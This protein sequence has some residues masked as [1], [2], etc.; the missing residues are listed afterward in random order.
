VKRLFVL[1]GS[2]TQFKNFCYDINNNYKPI[3]LSSIDMV[4]GIRDEEYIKYGTWYERHDA[5]NIIDY[6]ELHNCKEIHK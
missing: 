1:A 5:Q 3:Y 2:A 4:Y 6:L